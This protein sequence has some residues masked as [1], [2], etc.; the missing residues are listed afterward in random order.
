MGRHATLRAMTRNDTN[1]D[2][3]QNSKSGR[4]GSCIY[5]E[6]SEALQDVG[7]PFEPKLMIRCIT[8]KDMEDS[9]VCMLTSRT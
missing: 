2:G 7:C 1:Y 3:R 4:P 6:H 8:I 5:R 9:Q